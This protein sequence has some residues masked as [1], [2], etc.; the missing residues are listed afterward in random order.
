MRIGQRRARGAHLLLEAVRRPGQPVGHHVEGPRE[1][2]ELVGAA[3]RHAY[4][5]IP[6]GDGGGRVG[7][8]EYRGG[9]AARDGQ[10]AEGQH[11]EGDET[12]SS[13]QQE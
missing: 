13:G 5:E 2:C 1:A 6:V 9:E 12:E 4:R 7:H 11:A 3:L 8:G 10:R